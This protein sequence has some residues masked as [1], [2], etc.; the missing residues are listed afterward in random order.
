MFGI[1]SIS[2][3][4]KHIATFSTAN[5]RYITLLRSCNLGSRILVSLYWQE[6]PIRD[7]RVSVLRNASMVPDVMRF[8][9]IVQSEIT[10]FNTVQPSRWKINL[11][12][13]TMRF[14]QG[15]WRSAAQACSISSSTKSAWCRSSTRSALRM[16]ALSVC[17]SKNLSGRVAT[18]CSNSWNERLP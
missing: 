18:N 11:L 7:N 10:S 14:L 1:D 3:V 16:R 9:R 17:L 4:S 15:S 12:Q 13:P 8:I 5:R 2:A 6:A